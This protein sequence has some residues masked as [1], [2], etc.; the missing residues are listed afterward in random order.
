ME[1][2]RSIFTLR[3]FTAVSTVLGFSVLL[4]S[5]GGGGGG[6]GSVTGDLATDLVIAV[7][8][9]I[10]GTLR[11][12]NLTINPGVSLTSPSDLR[13]ETAG[14]V[15]L[16]GIISPTGA[17]TMIDPGGMDVGAT[18]EIDGGTGHVIFV[19]G[20]NHIPSEA[21]M[22]TDFATGNQVGGPRTRSASRSPRITRL[23]RGAPV[24]HIPL[25]KF[26]AGPKQKRNI[27]FDVDG[28]AKL[29]KP[30]TSFVQTMMAG[31]DGKDD[32]DKSCSAVGTN[33]KKG[34]SY[35]IQADDLEIDG[36][37]TINLGDGGAGGS[38]SAKA[39]CCPASAKGGNGG[40]TGTCVL[41]AG[42]GIV[43]NTSLTVTYG[44][45]G[46]GG[47]G[48]ATALDK[49]NVASCP[50]PAPCAATATGGI[51]G[52]GSFPAS[53]KGSVTGANLVTCNGGTGGDGGD[54]TA[55]GGAGGTS[56][57]C[58]GGQGGTGGAATA[59][60]GTG[61]DS[62][63]TASGGIALGQNG[64]IGGDGG[65]GTANGG[66]GGTGASCCT[67]TPV[68]GGKGGTGGNAT[69]TVG[70]GGVGTKANGSNG[71]PFGH[72]GNGGVGGAGNPVGPAGVGGIGINVP[73]GGPGSPGGPCEVTVPNTNETEPNDDE[74][75]A[76][77]M[78]GLTNPGESETGTGSLNGT[79]DKDHFV[80]QLGQGN[81]KLVVDTYPTGTGLY[82]HVGNNGP[83]NPPTNNPVFFQVV[84]TATVYIGFYNG[85]GNYHFTL[86]KVN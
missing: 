67:P 19:S 29:G 1:R 49:S 25:V 46:G 80:V 68:A 17:F 6:G 85:N 50:P 21:D 72:A 53:A 27:W 4:S 70:L 77:P 31:D 60:A 5:C 3:R 41:A 28:T 38:A 26:K 59:T 14:A 84:G 55:K 9:A 71:S 81:Y 7:N 18:G 64:F 8:T 73:N 32:L 34:G 23:G 40:D 69:V 62:V 33:G 2:N 56:T 15:T 78:P 43:V 57:C 74:Q 24:Y 52:K 51:G 35:S 44:N 30:S 54:S 10:T 39:G 83:L 66:L 75:H 79:S 13:I 48:S 12:K 65:D 16:N 42:N 36:T 20:T 47:S 58:P 82:L 61:G 76:T 45:G 63:A 37:V 11:A 86:T 22:D